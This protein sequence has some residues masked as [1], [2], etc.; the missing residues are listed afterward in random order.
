MTN[1]NEECVEK[2]LKS[3]NEN[4]GI[5]KYAFF[6]ESLGIEYEKEQHCNLAQVGSLLD[7]KT[8]GIAMRKGRLIN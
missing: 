5:S 2:A 1:N 4:E 3:G 6:M 7:S 8:Y